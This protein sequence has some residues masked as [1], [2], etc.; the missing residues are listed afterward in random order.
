MEMLEQI[1]GDL[2][3]KFTENLQDAKDK[4]MVIITRDRSRSI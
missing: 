1:I 2:K 4:P 3:R